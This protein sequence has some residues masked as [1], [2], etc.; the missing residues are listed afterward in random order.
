MNK[1]NS[2]A[3]V[4]PSASISSKGR[5]PP[6]LRSSNSINCTNNNEVGEDFS[7]AKLRGAVQNFEQKQKHHLSKTLQDKTLSLNINPTSVPVPSCPPPCKMITPPASTSMRKQPQTD[8]VRKSKTIGSN[9]YHPLS[10]KKAAKS[11]TPTSPVPSNDEDFSFKKLQKRAFKMEERNPLSCTKNKTET[12]DTEEEDFSFQK[13]KEKA[14]GQQKQKKQIRPTLKTPNKNPSSLSKPM[15]P[16]QNTGMVKPKQFTPTVPTE[17]PKLTR[18]SSA[19]TTTF[20]PQKYRFGTKVKQEEVQ[21]TDETHASV[22]KLSQWLSDDPFE[23]K[24]TIVVRRGMNIIQK[25]RAF[26]QN[27]VSQLVDSVQN[28]NVSRVERERQHFPQGKVSQGKSWLKG[29]FGEDKKE[30]ENIVGGDEDFSFQKLKQMAIGNE[31]K[32]LK[33]GNGP[34]LK[35]K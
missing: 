12:R 34:V 22:Q 29:A 35:K 18:G 17:K 11:N 13:L 10:E 9:A 8:F 23:K 33:S 25:S 7:F 21:A 19:K 4:R 15:T 2:H 28:K 20:N 14:L 24:K 30:N 27:Q 1:E 3:I 31:Q 6:R 5:T 16:S 26:E 32:C